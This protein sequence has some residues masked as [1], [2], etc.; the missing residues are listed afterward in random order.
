MKNF[1]LAGDFI[2]EIQATTSILKDNF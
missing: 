1:L 2:P